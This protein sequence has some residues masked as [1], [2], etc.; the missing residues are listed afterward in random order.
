[1][2][3]YEVLTTKDARERLPRALKDFRDHGAIAEP[4]VFGAHRKPEGVM[5]PFKLFLGMMEAFEDA[6][7]RARIAD[8][9]T[10]QAQEKDGTPLADVMQAMGYDPSEFGA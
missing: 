6:E 8:R 5:I 4:V 1:M 2:K 10:V 3:Q 7:F 9:L